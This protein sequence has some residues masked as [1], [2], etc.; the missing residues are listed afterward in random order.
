V[1]LGIS[2]I[3]PLYN[4]APHIK[5]TLESV[6]AQSVLPLEVIV[7][8]DG[9]TDGGADI[10][11]GLDNPGV[12]LIRQENKGVSI[13]RNAGVQLAS[14]AYVAFLDADDRW[15]SFHIEEMTKLIGAYPSCQLFST[16]NSVHMDGVNYFPA[17]PL[18]A[19]T[20]GLI[21]DF[22]LN[23]ANHLSMI[24]SSTACAH[25]ASMIES[26]GFPEDVSRGE[27]VIAW[28]RMALQHGMAHS[29]RV[30]AVYDRDATNRVAD[31]PDTEV[32]PS[33]A[34]LADLL[35]H[36]AK[37]SDVYAGVARLF[38]K[39]AFNTCAHKRDLDQRAGI[40]DI[41][42]LAMKCEMWILSF[43]IMLLFITPRPLIAYAKQFKYKRTLKERRA[44]PDDSGE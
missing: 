39:I 29:S 8:D 17:S 26:G 2:V 14:G 33:L 13:A 36:E 35:K 30:T 22:C 38:A 19:D 34:F 1:T 6:L 28:V 16:M 27:D 3:I 12:V 37:G 42:R 43:K 21:E 18:P 31:L 10:V 23:Y 4:K 24:T 20:D 5:K 7:V 25:R 32:L 41:L 40:A 9:S 15:E 44:K 11:A